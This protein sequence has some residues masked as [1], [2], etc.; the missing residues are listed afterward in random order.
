MES[1]G[2]PH[3]FIGHAYNRCKKTY[4]SNSSVNG[5][6][7]EHLICEAL[8][9]EGIRPF[10]CH[11]RFAQ[12]PITDFDVVCYDP[13]SP[14]VLSMKVSLRKRWKQADLEGMALRQVYRRAESYLIT[15]SKNEASSVKSKIEN[16]TVSGLNACVSADTEEFTL[17]LTKL[18][19]R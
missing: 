19:Q 12:V 3:I 1:Y 11:A 2:S 15:L 9:H 7:F 13:T 10:Y 18:K 4:K 8:N 5:A 17:L 14:V 6:V 16:G